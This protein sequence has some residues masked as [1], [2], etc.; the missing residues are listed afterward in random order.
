MPELRFSNGAVVVSGADA[1]ARRPATVLVVED[2][3]VDFAVITDLLR[4]LDCSVERARDLKAARRQAGQLG[5]TVD[6]VVLDLYLGDGWPATTLDALAMAWDHKP[7]IIVSGCSREL[8]IL[9]RGPHAKV[10]AFDKNAFDAPAFLAAVN[11]A[12]H[13]SHRTT[14]CGSSAG[15]CE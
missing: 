3:D 4:S 13:A 5:H 12:F 6:L 14:G 9:E 11:A 15:L 1:A 2:D 7:I 10:P 8:D